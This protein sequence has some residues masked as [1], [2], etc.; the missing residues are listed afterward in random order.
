MLVPAIRI[1][2]A[3]GFGLFFP[4]LTWSAEAQPAVGHVSHVDGSVTL[5]HRF[6]PGIARVGTVLVA[7]DQVHVA[8]GR[9]EITLSGGS[10]LQIDEHTRVGLH[11]ADRVELIEGRMFVTSHGAGAVIAEAGGKRL[12]VAPGSAA[13]VTT[14]GSNDLLVRVVDGDARV[15]SSWGSDVV[16]ATQSAF[17]SGPTGRPFV[18]P[19]VPSPHDTFHHWAGGRMMVLAP[20]A[21]FLPYAHPTF[22]Q[23]EYERLVRSERLERRRRGGDV[24]RVQRPADATGP[25]NGQRRG[26]E[27]RGDARDG[28][29]RAGDQ[30][31]RGQ[32]RDRER[33]DTTAPPPERR[34]VAKPPAAKPRGATAGLVVRPP[35]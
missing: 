14:T 4:L 31:R 12:H 15:E 9:A 2:L 34:A 32:R 19:W 1:V 7:G 20:P 17:V 30:T 29:E 21:T 26:G 25:A 8:M 11:A 22:R 10:L 27:R 33:D 35:Q 5:V 24:I 28:N 6:A 18:S 13:D 23:Q 3:L 16:T